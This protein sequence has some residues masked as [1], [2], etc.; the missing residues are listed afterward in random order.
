M[1]EKK[2]KVKKFFRDHEDDL[3]ITGAL[4]LGLSL[5]TTISYVTVKRGVD[6]FDIANIEHDS[7]CTGPI[8]ITF[9]NGNTSTYYP[10]KKTEN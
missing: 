4:F 5:S 6:K 3:L 8:W 2:E 9:R 1:N 10:N 7:E